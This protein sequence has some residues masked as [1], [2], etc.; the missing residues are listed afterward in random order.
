MLF[1]YDKTGELDHVAHYVK[2]D[3]KNLSCV[4]TTFHYKRN[5]NTVY[6]GFLPG[7]NSLGK[8]AEE[9]RYIFEDE[10]NQN[11]SANID[12]LVS[13]NGQKFDARV[14]AHDKETQAT[15]KTVTRAPVS[16]PVNT[17]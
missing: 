3:G 14:D 9:V 16:R 17:R 11:R 12:V 10:I 8:K 13:E 2:E 6:V 5:D 1:Y 4:G 15:T 7:I